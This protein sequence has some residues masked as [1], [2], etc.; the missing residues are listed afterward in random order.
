MSQLPPDL[1]LTSSE[2]LL[3]FQRPQEAAFSL[4]FRTLLSLRYLN[5]RLLLYRPLCMNCCREASDQGTS[6]EN[7]LLQQL[8]IAVL[9]RAYESASEVIEIVY[10]LSIVPQ[11]GSWLYLEGA[12]NIHHGKLRSTMC[13]LYPI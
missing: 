10:A 2:D 11:V 13:F 3:P 1:T 12:M 8:Q 9:H 4:K 6:M 7:I 5:T